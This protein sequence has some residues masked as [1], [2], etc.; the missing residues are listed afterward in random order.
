MILILCIQLDQ[1]LTLLTIRY[2]VKIGHQKLNTKL[3]SSAFSN[4]SGKF[5]Q[6]LPSSANWDNVYDTVTANSANW[7]EVVDVSNFVTSSTD[8]SGSY[9]LSSNGS[10]TTWHELEEEYELSGLNGVFISANSANKSIDISLTECYDIS[11]F[12]GILVSANSANKTIDITYSGNLDDLTNN[13]F[14]LQAGRNVVLTSG[15]N[16]D[17]KYLTISAAGIE[18]IGTPYELSGGE[19]IDIT[20]ATDGTKDYLVI[21]AKG[22]DSLGTPYNLSAGQNIGIQSATIGDDNYLVISANSNSNVSLPESANWNNTYG[23]V[24]SESANWN[25]VSSVTGNIIELKCWNK[26]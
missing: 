4:V 22:G 1:I 8:L 10:T 14:T 17:N 20:S 11:G 15:E 26:I 7:Y 13:T 25:S 21:S 5:V 19:N 24:N 18:S 23:T 3:N 9:I 16:G 2:L 12:N 6:T